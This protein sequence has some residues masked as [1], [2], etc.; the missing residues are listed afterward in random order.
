VASLKATLDENLQTP[1]R[2]DLVVNT[3][4]F[5]GNQLSP[6]AA[7]ELAALPAVDRAVATG[8]GPVRIGSTNTTV[9]NT[10]LEAIGEVVDVRT[11]SGSFADAG[12][13]GLAASRSKAED[14]HWH[15]GQRVRFTFADGA[16]VPVTVRAVYDDNELLGDVVI[17]TSLW[18][19][20]TPQP[21]DRSVFLTTAPGV[22]ERAAR[23]AIE[24]VATRFGGDLQDRAQYI[25]S[26]GGGFDF[27]LGIVYVL[28]LLAIVIALFGIANALSLAVYE[29]RREIGLLR[30]VGQTRAQVRSTLR[31]ESLIVATFG[32]LVGLTLGSFLGWSVF[33]AIGQRNAVTELPVGQLAVILVVGAVAGVLAGWRP[34]RRASRVPMLEAIEAR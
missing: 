20:H 34:A 15:V 10:D 21:T 17:P 19:A 3:S 7:E 8:E 4:A 31:L 13:R 33:A 16:T 29:R 24:P 1:F 22:T 32:T 27:L 6:G 9:T 14:E 18:A 11:V 2:A 23:V 30:A 26:A 12:E 25:D 5:G 28:L